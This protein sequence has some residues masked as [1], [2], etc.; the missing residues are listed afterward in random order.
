MVDKKHPQVYDSSIIPEI[1][2][3][4]SGGKMYYK[5]AK[6]LIDEAKKLGY[7]GTDWEQGFLARLEAMSPDILRPEDALSVEEFYRRAAGG[8]FRIRGSRRSCVVADDF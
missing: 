7:H 6:I 4:K 5:D 1:H 2:P 3:G 8:N